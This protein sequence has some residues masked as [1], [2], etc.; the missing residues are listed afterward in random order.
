MACLPDHR[1]FR[2]H[3]PRRGSHLDAPAR[4]DA[5]RHRLHLLHHP[6]RIPG[7][8]GDRQHR[9]LHAGARH[10]QSQ[11][12]AGLEPDAAGRRGRLDRVHAGVFAALLAHQSAALHQPLVYLPDR[13]G[14]LFMGAP[15]GHTLVGRELSPR[16]GSRRQ[17]GGRPGPPGGR[18]LRRQH[19]RR[20][21]GRALRQHDP[22]SVD[23][24]R[25]QPGGL[26]RDPGSQRPAD[27]G[28]AP[29]AIPSHACTGHRRGGGRR[30]PA[31]KYR[32]ARAGHADR[33]RAPH[34]DVDG[35]LGGALHR[36]RHQLLHRHHQVGRWRRPIPCQRQSGGLHRVLRHAPAAHARPPAGAGAQ[37]SEIRA[38][39]RL[40]R[41][42]DGRKFRRASRGQ[43][44]RH[45]RDGAADS[46]HRHQ[47][48]RSRRTTSSSTTRAPK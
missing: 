47:I 22:G 28:P 12:P 40:R 38:D 46:A 31:G 16:P 33:L 30:A 42:R 23:R 5:R 39:C 35:P 48:F 21:S 19:R 15:P 27:A 41:G 14:A 17:R 2:R 36:R 29:A 7:W 8:H 9:R 4:T 44:H 13:H 34:D 26:S 37:R 6:G 1:A 25:P 32:G 10:A 45:L 18:Y 11:G 24:H 3:R 20:D 43:T